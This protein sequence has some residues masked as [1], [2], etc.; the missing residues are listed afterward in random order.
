MLVIDELGY[1][2]LDLAGVVEERPR[3]PCEQIGWSIGRSNADRGAGLLHSGGEASAQRP[4]SQERSV[5]GGNRGASS[6]GEGK[7][8]H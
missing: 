8:S 3:W 2:L 1:T 7:F 5:T 4:T 6:L